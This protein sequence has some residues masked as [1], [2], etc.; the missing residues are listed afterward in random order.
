MNSP[1]N[2][3]VHAMRYEAQGIVSV[4]LRDVGAHGGERHVI[5]ERARCNLRGVRARSQGLERVVRLLRVLVMR[6]RR[7]RRR[8]IVHV[9]IGDGP[10]RRIDLHREEIVADVRITDV[11]ERLSVG[12]DGGL[13]RAGE[14][15]RHLVRLPGRDLPRVDVRDLGAIG[16]E[17]EPLSVG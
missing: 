3:R 5:P 15:V 1:L 17:E 2:L 7:R 9:R 8:A 6:R 4:E 13:E 16:V 14:H 12:G 10:R 11:R